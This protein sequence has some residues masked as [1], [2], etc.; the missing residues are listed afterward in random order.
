MDNNF[1]NFPLIN[2]QWFSGNFWDSPEN[3]NMDGATGGNE[4]PKVDFK[5]DK[6]HLTQ[7]QLNYMRVA[8]AKNAG[9]SS[10]CYSTELTLTL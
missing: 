9:E 5:K 6:Q 8:Q 4:M 1:S 3:L 2:I 7:A 10:G